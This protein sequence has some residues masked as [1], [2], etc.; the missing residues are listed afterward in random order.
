MWQVYV[1][2]GPNLNLLGEREPG[3]YGRTSLQELAKQLR[4]KAAELKCSL[5]FFQSNS[6][7]DIIDYLHDHRVELDGLL[8]N[9]GGL[10]HTS[11]ALRDALAALGRPAVEVHISDISSREAFRQHSYVRDVCIAQIS[12][13]GAS[14]YAL[15]LQTLVEH[16]E[17]AQT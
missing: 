17:R 1:I 6:E 9:P 5:R 4:D 14:G 10:T 11:I 15:A 13:Q 16:L 2:N 12:G 8:I 7:G 3:V